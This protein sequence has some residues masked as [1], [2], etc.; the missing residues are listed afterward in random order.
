MSRVSGQ[1]R[2]GAHRFTGAATRATARMFAAWSRLRRSKQPTAYARKVLLNRHLLEHPSPNGVGASYSVASCDLR[3]LMDQPPR[4]SRRTT[5]PAGTTTADSPSSSGGTC[6]KARCGRWGTVALSNHPVRLSP[7]HRPTTTPHRHGSSGST[8]SWRPL[9]KE[10][11][12]FA[13]LPRQIPAQCNS[14]FLRGR[15]AAGLL[16]LLQSARPRRGVRPYARQASSSRTGRANPLSR[17]SPNSTKATPLGE[18]DSTTLPL[19]RTC[20]A[21]AWAAIRAARLTVR[22]K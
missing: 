3:I 21:P 18:A 17:S 22:P 5:L 16:G 7:L 8:P 1:A 11:L 15:G 10:S 9:M 12:H 4:R 20:P 6:R 2:P 14:A 19:T 13:G